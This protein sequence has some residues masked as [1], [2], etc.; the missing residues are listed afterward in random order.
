MPRVLPHPAVEDL[1]AFALGQLDDET[2]AAVAEHVTT[3]PQCQAATARAPSDGFVS[4]LREARSLSDT[5]KG[6]ADTGLNVPLDC[7]AVLAEHPRYRPIRL[8]GRGGLGA[9]WLAEHRLMG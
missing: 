5:L 3:C 7:P 4:L 6:E 2:F 1:E 8:L 9:V